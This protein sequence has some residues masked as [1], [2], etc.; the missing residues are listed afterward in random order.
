MLPCFKSPRNFSTLTGSKLTKQRGDILSESIIA[1]LLFAIAGVGITHITSKVAV[2]Q[3]D[4][5]VQQQ[6]VNEMRSIVMNR[7]DATQLCNGAALS[8]ES[9]QTEITVHGCATTTATVN[10]VNLSGISAPLV[11]A[12]NVAELGEIHV[13]GVVAE[14]TEDGGDE[15]PYDGY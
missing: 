9:F 10:G 3:R 6:V 12:A 15:T 4:A 8:T 13:G 7:Q 14:V 5:K 1:V 2:A 11:L